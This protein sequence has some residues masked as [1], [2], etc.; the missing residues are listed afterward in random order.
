MYTVGQK[1]Y[2]TGEEGKKEW[3][4]GKRPVGMGRGNLV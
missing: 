1:C 4:K 3:R 2:E